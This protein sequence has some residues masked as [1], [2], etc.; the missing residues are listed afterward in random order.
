MTKN[1][2]FKREKKTDEQ[3]YL[4]NYY[5]SGVFRNYRIVE[6]R[7]KSLCKVT[8]YYGVNS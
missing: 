5:N 8:L 7:W 3:N 6:T 2:D 4:H 1:H